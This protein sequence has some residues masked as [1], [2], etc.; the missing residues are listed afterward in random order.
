MGHKEI[1]LLYL[2]GQRNTALNCY[3]LICAF[4]GKTHWKNPPVVPKNKFF[5]HTTKIEF[6]CAR[7]YR[8]SDVSRARSQVFSGSPRR[9]QLTNS[10]RNCA[11]HRD[12][13]RRSLRPRKM[14]IFAVVCFYPR[15]RAT[16]IFFLLLFTTRLTGYLLPELFLLFRDF[17]QIAFRGKWER[18]II[19]FELGVVDGIFPEFFKKFIKRQFV[20][21]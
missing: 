9:S 19:F 3:N 16:F 1:F 5:L 13:I 11:T 15:A 14:Y 20:Y 6:A 10:S 17:R 12:Y 2:H 18:W 7:R 4:F 21:F 8:W